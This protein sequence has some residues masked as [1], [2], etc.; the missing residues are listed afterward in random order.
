M[1]HC[2]L[3]M[4]I[5]YSMCTLISCN[6]GVPQTQFCNQPHDVDKLCIV[7]QSLFVHLEPVG[8]TCTHVP[9]V[10]CEVMYSLFPCISF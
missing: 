1:R 8:I 10:H 7:I 3:S 2:K 5:K 6:Y 9:T 4:Y